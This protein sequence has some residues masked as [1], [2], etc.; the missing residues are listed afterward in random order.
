[1]GQ[2][3]GC[4]ETQPNCRDAVGRGRDDGRE[5]RLG[6]LFGGKELFELEWRL[7]F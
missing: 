7:W 6:L 2:G 1:M 5:G 4:V 3:R